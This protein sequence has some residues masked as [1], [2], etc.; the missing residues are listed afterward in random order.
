VSAFRARGLLRRGRGA[1]VWAVAAAYRALGGLGKGFRVCGVHGILCG[2]PGRMW[3]GVR[4]GG[5]LF[6]G[7]LDPVARGVR[8]GAAPIGA[9]GAG[10]RFAGWAGAGFRGGVRFALWARGGC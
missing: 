10:V 8:S 6:E 9:Y 4:F 1:S 3:G 2:F 7:V 5:S